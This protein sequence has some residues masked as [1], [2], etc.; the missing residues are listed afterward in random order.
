[1]K[2]IVLIIVL[3]ILS[4]SLKSQTYD[5][6]VYIPAE[7]EACPSTFNTD[8]DSILFYSAFTYYTQRR[9]NC[10]NNDLIMKGVVKH[11][12]PWNKLSKK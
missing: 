8:A 3:A 10:P 4:L 11:S 2:K 5:T 6:L 9:L 7:I 12:I 1:M